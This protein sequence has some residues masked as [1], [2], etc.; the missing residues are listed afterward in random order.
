MASS[1]LNVA[2]LDRTSQDT[3]AQC[4]ALHQNRQAWATVKESHLLE[5]HDRI[6]GRAFRT[7][8]EKTWVNVTTLS[9]AGSCCLLG[10]CWFCCGGWR[11]ARMTR[12]ISLWFTTSHNSPFYFYFYFF[13]SGWKISIIL[14]WWSIPS[15]LLFRQGW[16]REFKMSLAL[17]THY[18]ISESMLYK[19]RVV[20]SQKADLGLKR[21][22]SVWNT[23][24]TL[25]INAT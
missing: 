25:G 23:L 2:A 17:K 6:R 16:P 20:F 12:F 19:C 15:F 24:P 14:L 18:E 9:Q 11:R 1:H 7:C 13:C 5:N 4:V 3:P 22:C 8:Q 10:G 21:M